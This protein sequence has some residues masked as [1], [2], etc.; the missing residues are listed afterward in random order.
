MIYLLDATMQWIHHYLLDKSMAFGSTN[1]LDSDLSAREH[2]LWTTRVRWILKEYGTV[3]HL[4]LVSPKVWHYSLS[5][6]IWIWTW[7]VYI[8]LAGFKFNFIIRTNNRFNS[9]GWR[10]Q[11]RF[12]MP[13]KRCIIS[14][15][16]ASYR[17]ITYSYTKIVTFVLLLTPFLKKKALLMMMTIIIINNII[18][19]TIIHSLHNIITNYY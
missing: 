8:Q 19:I 7:S 13:A 16:L 9:I 6:Q 14:G 3:V 12:V 4:N 1:P 10:S 11:W 5:G 18:T 2:N 15:K 17:K